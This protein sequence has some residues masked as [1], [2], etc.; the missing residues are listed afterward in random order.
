MRRETLP[1]LVAFLERRKIEHFVH[2]T[3]FENLEGILRSGLIPPLALEKLTLPTPWVRTDTARWDG[4]PEASC[5][6]VTNPNH[7]MFKSKRGDGKAWVVLGFSAA[8]ILQL[9]SYFMSKNAATGG[10]KFRTGATMK[11]LPKQAT[12]QAFEGMFPNEGW[13]DMLKI[14]LN[15]TLDSQAEVM[16]LETIPPGMLTFLAPFGAP[17]TGLEPL[18]PLCPPHVEFLTE[19]SDRRTQ[20]ISARVDDPFWLSIKYGRTTQT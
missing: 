18:L 9:P 20:L 12:P 6:S 7:S 17:S 1:E 4:M 2:F 11:Y 14:Q 15:E 13:R 5:L 8:K 3:R 19:K 10:R 16:V